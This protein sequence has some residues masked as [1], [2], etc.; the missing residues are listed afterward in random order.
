MYIFMHTYNK[1]IYGIIDKP[2]TEK[3]NIYFAHHNGFTRVNLKL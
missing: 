2:R 1:P 3:N